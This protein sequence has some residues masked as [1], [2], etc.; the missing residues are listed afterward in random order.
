MTTTPEG[1][2]I[3]GTVLLAIEALKLDFQPTEF[4]VKPDGQGGAHVRFGPVAL[5]AVYVQRESWIGGH[6]PAQIPYADVY[7][8]FVR[9]D[10]ARIDG[11]LLVAPMA[12]GQ[13]FMGLPAVQVS[14]RSNRRDASIETVKMKFK[15][16]L[17]WVNSQ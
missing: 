13:V 12:N 1:P 16:V 11:Q 10:L 5:S 15:K 14:R 4:V 2:T 8:I 6:L 7:P 3:A 9:G 17:D